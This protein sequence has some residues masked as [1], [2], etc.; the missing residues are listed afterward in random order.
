MFTCIFTIIHNTHIYIHNTESWTPFF[1]QKKDD[2]DDNVMMMMMMMIMWWWW[3]LTHND[4]WPLLGRRSI[5]VSKQGGS[6][7]LKFD[8]NWERKSTICVNVIDKTK[9]TTQLNWT[10]NTWQSRP[11]WVKRGGRNGSIFRHRRCISKALLWTWDLCCEELV[12]I[13]QILPLQLKLCLSIYHD[14][15]HYSRHWY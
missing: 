13:V 8:S 1:Y 6:L 5:P 11:T 9:L 12:A 7:K 3:L 2:D 15:N 14:R 4:F 10:H